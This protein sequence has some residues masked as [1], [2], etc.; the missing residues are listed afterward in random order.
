MARRPR[1]FGAFR[2]FR[3]GNRENVWCAILTTANAISAATAEEQVIVAGIDW[4]G[5]SGAEATLVRIRAYFGFGITPGATGQGTVQAIVYKANEDVPVFATPWA[6]GTLVQ[7]DILFA[8]AYQVPRLTTEVH[9]QNYELDI[10]VKRKIL[11]SDEIR[12]A[13]STPFSGQYQ[14][15]SRALVII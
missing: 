12:F 6:V 11:G 2:R 4:S 15:S 14:L 7:E 3:R 10:P 9:A 5:L 13:I 8:A 1:R